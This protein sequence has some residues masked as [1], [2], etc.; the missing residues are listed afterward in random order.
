MQPPET[1]DD[2]KSSERSIRIERKREDCYRRFQLTEEQC[3]C[4]MARFEKVRPF[5]NQGK[6]SL[7]FRK[8]EAT[9]ACIMHGSAEEAED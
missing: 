1:F 5:K 7:D 8:N 3:A 6:V 2:D 4:T 9:E